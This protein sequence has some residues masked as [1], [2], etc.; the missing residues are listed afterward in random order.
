VSLAA[1]RQSEQKDQKVWY[2]DRSVI[3]VLKKTKQEVVS[4]FRCAG[5]LDAA[6]RVF[7]RKGFNGATVDEIA[8]AA[9]LAK[10]TVYL[11]FQS[12]REI[13]LEAL[14]QGLGG[15]IEET[16]RNLD[17]APTLAE[18]IRAFITTRIRYAEEN[19]DFISIYHAEFG[20]LAPTFLNKG[21]RSLY[22]QQAKILEA[23]LR[24]A[25]VQGHIRPIRPDAAAFAVYEMTRGLI[26]RRLLGW[27]KAS[28][29]E[30]ADC[31]FE[32]IWRGLSSPA[33]PAAR[34]EARCIES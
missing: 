16:K 7:A 21:F 19:R 24:D 8:G 2:T 34:E 32:L 27:S 25:R 22:L 13:Y 6:R 14:K 3:T 15:L 12:K 28:A 1:D 17:A 10:G 30:D 33:V 11:Y 9:G 26:T 18:K 31:L 23:V 4:E 5:I 20:N 29:A